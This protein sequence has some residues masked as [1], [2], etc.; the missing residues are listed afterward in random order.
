MYL[1]EAGILRFSREAGIAVVVIRS[2]GIKRKPA[3]SR[4]IAMSF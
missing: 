4:W 1:Q 3:L 2:Y